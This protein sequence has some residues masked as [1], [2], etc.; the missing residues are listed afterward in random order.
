MATA[1]TWGKRAD[2]YVLKIEPQV[3]TA[4]LNAERIVP[5]PGGRF[6]IVQDSAYIEMLERHFIKTWGS[7]QAPGH[8]LH[9]HR[10]VDPRSRN[11]DPHADDCIVSAL[12]EK[13]AE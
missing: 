10:F 2:G 11:H 12:L 8:C 13:Y 1:D 9:C 4:V 6:Q 5:L 7:S 3:M